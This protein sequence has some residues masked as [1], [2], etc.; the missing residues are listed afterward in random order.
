MERNRRTLKSIQV[1]R[2]L[3]R[4]MLYFTPNIFGTII[5]G[6]ERGTARSTRFALHTQPEFL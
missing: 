3:R 5:F 6:I 2:A 4:A 1:D